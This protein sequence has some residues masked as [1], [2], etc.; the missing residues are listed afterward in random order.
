M[1]VFGSYAK[2][3]DGLYKDKD[4]AAE[5]NFLE[6]VFAQYSSN[7]IV[8]ILD[9]GCGTG[10][11]A[12]PLA[13][14]GYHVIGVDR[15]E[16]MLAEARTKGN[17]MSSDFVQADISNI[18]MDKTFDAVIAMF[19]V[20]S[21]MTTNEGLMGAIRTA[22]HHL[23]PGG[24]FFFD[25]W[26]GPA[27]LTQRPSDRYKIMENDGDRIVRFVHPEMNLLKHTVD[28]NYKVLLTRDKTIISEVDET[29]QMRFFFPMEISHYL[30]QSSFRVRKLCPFL[31][32]DKELTEHDWN[33]AVIAEAE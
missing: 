27:V 9:L 2:F 17:R 29:H 24:L 25:A 3:Y 21:Y 33:L 18:R 30:E 28:V 22:R 31:R 19:A 26:F 1:S 23:R 13:E 5:C 6:E 14:R 7:K 12:I 10:G 15:S 20:M 11:H 8:T 16:A 32:I 4:Y